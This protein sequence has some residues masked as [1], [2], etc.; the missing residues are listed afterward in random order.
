MLE[1]ILDTETTGL[2]TKENHRI[3]EI[4]C[5]ELNDQITTGKNFHKYINPERKISIDAY[6]MHGYTDKFLENKEKF[7]EIPDK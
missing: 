6:K 2:S 3:V 5:I 1:V 4:G 7:S